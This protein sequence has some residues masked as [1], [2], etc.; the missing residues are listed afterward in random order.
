MEAARALKRKMRR[1]GGKNGEAIVYDTRED[2]EK[3]A[4]QR[5]EEEMKRF[6]ELLGDN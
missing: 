2:I 5:E 3:L 4:K 1:I 6:D